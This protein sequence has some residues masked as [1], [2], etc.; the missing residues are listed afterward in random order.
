MAEMADDRSCGGIKCG[1]ADHEGSGEGEY[2]LTFGPSTFLADSNS[3][4]RRQIDDN[5]LEQARREHRRQQ[6]CRERHHQGEI[7]HTPRR[8]SLRVDDR[9]VPDDLSCR[10][11][12]MIPGRFEL[13]LESPARP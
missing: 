10:R 2:A 4:H 3:R 11:T 13:E 12:T 5:E 6:T 8:S 1:E 9:Q 7:P